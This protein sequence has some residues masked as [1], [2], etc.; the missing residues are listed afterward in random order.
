MLGLTH[1]LA[2]EKDFREL[3]RRMEYGGCPVVYSG[4]SG[5][6]KSHA[7][8]ALRR[9]SGRPLVLICPDELEAERMRGDLE[10]LCQEEVYPL[11]GREFTFFHATSVSRTGEQ[12]RLRTLAALLRGTAGVVVTTPDGLMQRTVPKERLE[13]AAVT[14]RQGEE[15]PPEKLVQA[16]LRCGYRRYDAVEGPGQFAARGGIVDFFSP[17]YPQPV[18]CDFFGDELDAMGFFDAATQRRTENVTSAELLPSAEALPALADGGE[19]GLADR[20][21]EL[22]RRMKRR[23]NPP[24]ELIRN[25]TADL[26]R[27]RQGLPFA[28]ADKLMALSFSALA[29]AADYI[30]LDAAV[31]MAEPAAC[32]ERAKNWVWQ[33]GQ[34]TETLLESAQMDG[35]FAAFYRPWDEVAEGLK[36][37]PVVFMDSF[38]GSRYPL[39]P[40]A[41]LDLTAKQLPSYGGSLSTAAGDILHYAG[42][43][44]RVVVCCGDRRKA[45]I[46]C[47]YLEDREIR[48]YVDETLGALGEPGRCAVTVGSLSAGM[49][50]P[51][52]RLAVMTEGQFTQ[53]YRQE[54]ARRKGSSSRQKLQSYTDLSRGDL[55]VHDTHGIGRFMGIE[56]LQT[57]GVYKDYIKI[58]YAGTDVLYVPATQLDMVSKYI[59]SGGEDAPARL[60]KLGGTDWARAKSRAKK[61]AADLAEGLIKLYA[62]RSRRPGYAFGPDTVWQ[63]EF[64]DRFE[65]TETQD[66]L[67]SIAEIKA[68]MEKPVPMDRLLCGDVG[69][70]KTE[71]AFRAVMK[72]VMAGKQAA[73]LVPTTV[74]AQ[75]HYVTAMKRFAGLPLQ[76]QVLSRFRSAGQIKEA[77]RAAAD[78]SADILIGTHRL[79]QKDVR[80]RDLGLLVVDEEQRFGVSHKERLKEMS[81][82]VDVLTLSATP[83]P[84]TLN[85]AL[86]G[87]RDMSSIEE[88]PVGRHP[89]QTYV[90]EHDWSVL[91]DAIRREVSRGG[92][93]YYLHNRVESIDR[94]AARIRQLADGVSVAVAHGQMDE[95][96][97]NAVMDRV[98]SGEV[99]VLVCTTII[100]TGIDIPNVNTLIIEDADRLGLAQ[101]HQIRGRVGRS[102]RHAFAYFTFRQGKVLTEVAAKRLAA[103]REYAEFNSG[104]RIAMRD[105]EIRGAGNLLGAEQSGH[106]MSVGFDMY[107]KLLEEAVLEQKGEKK[108][109]KTACSADLSVDAAIPES[110]V[111]SPEQRMDLYRRIA[112]IRSEEDAD[113][114][115]DE[116]IDR[117]GDPPRGVNNLIQVALMRGEAAEAGITEIVQRSGRLLFKLRDFDM[118]RIS[119]LYQQQDF[120]GRLK[121]EAGTVPGVSLRLQQGDVIRQAVRFIR[122]YRSIGA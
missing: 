68:D 82:N 53:R 31:V 113:D 43:G 54:S 100:E 106:M 42:D 67:R 19:A 101:L 39:A 28:A 12:T 76:I 69:F 121:V 4:L 104:F 71:V 86:A 44:Y 24:A 84:R 88:P 115:T 109:L 87:I 116:L 110:Y 79:L 35:S 8:A 30:P 1:A 32:G 117:F 107:L 83:I 40:R 78:G 14:V 85:M 3:L 49:E 22:L 75:Q 97:L 41:L 61:A 56:Q 26:E 50:Y 111:E 91:A 93:V 45:D 34:D 89:V 11:Y 47:R 63:S 98:A 81:R 119:A 37:Y 60:S 112:L 7:A 5:I 122:A 13:E 77:L 92:Q 59:G 29:C 10:T 105:L 90:L 57:D 9:E 118:E 65:Y 62:E 96:A 80:F 46:L 23:K 55:V 73:I 95:S 18:R 66:Q 6:H 99:Q 15:L 38:R 64:E 17:A 48:A 114:M 72:C 74:L 102:S 21:E 33:L 103:I 36:E 25:L 120:R 2:Q 108:P 27:L 58:A 52:I 70:G 51:G 94:C 16:L 20:L